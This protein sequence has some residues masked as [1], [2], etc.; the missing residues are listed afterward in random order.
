[1]DRGPR[2]KGR[3]E[4][5][6]WLG[7]V[8]LSFNLQPNESPEYSS[9]TCNPLK[10]PKADKYT[11]FVDLYSVTAFHLG[12]EGDG[13]TVMVRAQFGA[14]KSEPIAAKRSKKS[15]GYEFKD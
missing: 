9:Q 4:G 13:K 8:L 10:E 2:T 6:C 5:S 15:G 14:A 11:V 7:R 1:M 12:E 3:R